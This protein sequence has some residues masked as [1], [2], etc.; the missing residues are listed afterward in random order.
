M[1]QPWQSAKKS[2]G[3]ESRFKSFVRR[4]A[5]TSQSSQMRTGWQIFFHLLFMWLH[6]RINW[7]PN[8]KARAFL[9]MK[10]TAW[11]RLSWERCSVFQANLR[12]TPSL[13]CQSWKDSHHQLITSAGTLPCQEHCMVSF[14]DLRTIEDEINRISSPFTCSVD[15]APSDW[16]AVRCSTGRV[17]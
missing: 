5:M 2:L 6:W 16:P 12:A 14:E 4:K 13:T 9:F 1:A 7:T 10:C 15:T 11:W 17:L 8:C 3:P